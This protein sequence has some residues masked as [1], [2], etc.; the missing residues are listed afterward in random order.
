VPQQTESDWLF[1]SSSVLAVLVA[2]A[3]QMTAMARQSFVADEPFFLLAGYRAIHDGTNT[4]NLEHP[5]LVKMLAALPLFRFS[6]PDADPS[7][8][9]FPNR[10]QATSVRLASRCILLVTVAIPFLIGCFLFGWEVATVRVGVLLALSLAFSFTVVPYLTITQTDAAVSLGYV[11]T[12][13][14]AIRFLRQPTFMRSCFLGLGFGIAIATKFSG[15]LLLPS[16][17]FVLFTARDPYASR[18]RRWAYGGVV[19]AVSLLL[20]YGTY[21]VANWQYD[22][23]VGR[24]T[25]SRY[26]QNHTLF[27]VDDEMRPYEQMLLRIEEIDPM[28]AQWS[29]GLL[30][31]AI[32]NRMGVWTSYAFGLVSSRGWWWFFPL[33]FLIRTPLVL[34][35]ASC[36]S[37]VGWL[38]PRSAQ[39]AKEN[40]HE[41]QMTTLLVLTTSVYLGMALST[42]YNMGIRHLLPILPVLYLPAV[43]WAAH[44]RFTA[45]LLVGSLLFEAV[46]LQPVWMSATNTWWL[47]ERNP[48]RCAVISDCEYKQNFLALDHVRAQ[49]QIDQL[50]VAF[51]LLTDAELDAYLPG[52][53]KVDPTSP[54][55]PGWHAVNIFIEEFFPAVE[56]AHR[57]QVHNYDSLMQTGAPWKRYYDTV[58]SLGRNHGYV[59]G[60]F[61]LY[62][63]PPSSEL[64]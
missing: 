22:S 43:R 21:R 55:L 24:N 41:K 31:L 8:L 16:I 59:A 28:V 19:F 2:V 38:L 46:V 20:L 40:S 60:T 18:G 5:P 62:Y 48:T 34:L 45:C 10:T 30:G 12:L 9:I 33:L 11:L 64:R 17:G 35:L 23:A 14:A 51:P 57:D 37:L 13:V 6:G 49:Y 3:L 52:A 4:L 58:R 7:Q 15:V 50:H 32:Q 47:G 26:C 56:K 36:C 42:S 44:R 25:I 29:T 53:V 54:L 1:I 27:R 63:I 39:L 61:H